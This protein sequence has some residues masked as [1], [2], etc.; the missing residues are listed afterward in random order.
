M[1]ELLEY[2]NKQIELLSKVKLNTMDED[3]NELECFDGEGIFEDGCVSGKQ[4]AYLDIR[5][6]INGYMKKDEKEPYLRKF[7]V[8]C[9]SCDG[10]GKDGSCDWCE[11]SGYTIVTTK[12][13]KVPLGAFEEIK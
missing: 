6:R 4:S 10:T 8:I 13:G 2:V 1:E 12:G 3:G 7:K 5:Q 11:G 9:D